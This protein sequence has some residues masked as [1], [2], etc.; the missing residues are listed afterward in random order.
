MAQLEPLSSP[1][2]LPGDITAPPHPPLWGRYHGPQ[3]RNAHQHG[4]L[5]ASSPVLGAELLQVNP[6]TYS[7]GRGLN[8][9]PSSH[10][11]S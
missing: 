3:Q 11:P 8:F 7:V 10:H 5:L 9:P 4:R 6:Y 1:V 2:S